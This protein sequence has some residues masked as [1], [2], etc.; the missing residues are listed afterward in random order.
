MR[1]VSVS[2]QWAGAFLNAVPKSKE[3]RIPTWAMRIAVQRRLGLPLQV[4]AFAST[5]LSKHGKRFDVMGDVAQNDGE[6]GH[7]TR[8]YLILESLFDALRRI[9]GGR[10]QKEP[11]DY[12]DYSDY[13][14]DLTVR[15]GPDFKVLDLK[16]KDP[17]GSD[18]S[19]TEHRGAFVAFGN[20]RRE[21]RAEVLGLRERGAPGDG[22]WNA[23]K[24]TGYVKAEAGGL[25]AG[26]RERRGGDGGAG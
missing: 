19:E 24:G 5:R 9:W 20:T 26:D 16:T 10:A 23:R 6:A 13:R 14:P 18:V 8:H 2:Q 21:A 7:Q 11:K 1:F 17:V 22:A 4:A 15:D 3:F 12:G 25:Q